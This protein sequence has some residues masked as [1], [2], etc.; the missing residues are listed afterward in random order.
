M[1]DGRPVPQAICDMSGFKVPAHSLQRQWDN[2]MVAPRFLE[3]RNPQDFVTGVRDDQVLRVSRPEPIDVF[4][5]TQITP[6]DL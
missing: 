6:E 5:S 1:K 3:K 2:A 4:I